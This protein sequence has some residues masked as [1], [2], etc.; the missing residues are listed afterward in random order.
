VRDLRFMT[1]FAR[2]W[3]T[4]RVSTAAAL[5]GLAAQPLEARRQQLWAAVRKPPVKAGTPGAAPS[6]AIMT[7]DTRTFARGGKSE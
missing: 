5:L 1:R 4:G 2:L 6:R 7:R 3:E